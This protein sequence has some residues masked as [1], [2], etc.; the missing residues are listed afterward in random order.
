M[1]GDN[2]DNGDQELELKVTAIVWKC[3][4]ILALAKGL[5][6]LGKRPDASD[7]QMLVDQD[8]CPH[9]WVVSKHT[10]RLQSCTAT[11]LVTLA[12]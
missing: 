1:D 4:A 8:M 6:L 9:C 5:E 7:V 10:V 12:A 11:T 2:R 3:R